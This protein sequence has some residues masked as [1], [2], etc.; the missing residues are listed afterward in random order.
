M[1]K[2]HIND[3]GEVGRC[4]ATKAKCPFGGASGLENHYSSREEAV[5]FA[6]SSMD[7]FSDLGT[8]SK[9]RPT[10][11]QTTKDSLR[12]SLIDYGVMKK[13]DLPE[14]SN[15]SELVRD[16]FDGDKR[17]FEAFKNLISNETLSAELKAPLAHL[18]NRGVTVDQVQDVNSLAQ[19]TATV[20]VL[21]DSL[22]GISLAQLQKNRP[23]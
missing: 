20:D 16:W 7:G 9:K 10:E 22:R 12:K 17:K 19:G 8:A 11:F 4:S 6:A 2:W 15:N 13:A 1:I 14:V 18:I 3:S 21:D 23:F 5:R